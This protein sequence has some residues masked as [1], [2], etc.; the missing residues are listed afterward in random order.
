MGI[1]F[2]FSFALLQGG[3]GGGL[4]GLV[5]FILLFILAYF[6]LIRPQQRRRA[7]SEREGQGIPRSVGNA[8]IGLWIL[9]GFFVGSL[10]G[11]LVR[12][13]IPI[14]GQLPFESV[15]SRGSTLRGAD[16]L[17]I[18]VAQ[19]SFNYLLFGGIVGGL[20]M[21]A[22]GYSISKSR[23]GVITVPRNDQ[24]A[25]PDIGHDDVAKRIRKL[26]ELKQEG[27]I[28]E[29]DFLMKKSQLLDQL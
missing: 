14:I 24:V 2:N 25:R 21:G 9:V 22:I 4:I 26:A 27:L 29:E 16:Q 12:P 1:A 13:S 7:Q 28:T 15:V 18:S 3:A 11:Y 5:P 19:S 10:I 20:V 6:L 17:F 23:S 8:G